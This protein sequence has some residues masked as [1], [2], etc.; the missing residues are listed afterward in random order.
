MDDRV[1]AVEGDVHILKDWRSGTVD[2]HISATKFSVQTLNDYITALKASKEIEDKLA[3][4]RHK[5][6]SQKLTIINI[7]LT[8]LLFFCAA[9]STFIAYE[10]A[11]HHSLNVIPLLHGQIDVPRLAMEATVPNLPR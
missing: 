5:S 2:P 6:N 10:S 3:E 8:V 11:E 4:E 9:A 1:R 7:L